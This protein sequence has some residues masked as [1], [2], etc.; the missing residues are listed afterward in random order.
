MR[1]RLAALRLFTRVARTG[2]FSR[3]GRELGYSQPSA[4]RVVAELERELGTAL[5]ARGGWSVVVLERAPRHERG[6]NSHYTGGAMRVSH[7]GVDDLV[8]LMPDKQPIVS[9]FKN[10]RKFWRKAVKH[11]IPAGEQ[12]LQIMALD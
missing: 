2:S 10:A 1:D 9:S 12:R 6:G 7:E 4:S 5:L 11:H 3:A 8:K